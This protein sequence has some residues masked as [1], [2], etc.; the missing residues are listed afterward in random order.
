M[1]RVL[2]GVPPAASLEPLRFACNNWK[3]LHRLTMNRFI[4]GDLFKIPQ[5]SF[6][7]SSKTLINHHKSNS[8]FP[9][10]QL[11]SST[12]S[13]YQWW[14]R[15]TRGP[16]VLLHH[17]SSLW[18]RHGLAAHAVAAEA[19]HRHPTR[20]ACNPGRARRTRSIS[21]RLPTMPV[22]LPVRRARAAACSLGRDALN[23]GRWVNADRV[24]P[25]TA[26]LEHVPVKDVVVGES[27]LVEQVAKELP[28][29]A[30]R[31][32]GRKP[33][34]EDV[35]DCSIQ[36]GS[37]LPIVWLLFKPHCPAVV[38]VCGEFGGCALAQGINWSS[39][40]FLRNAWNVD[41]E[42]LGKEGP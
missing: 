3:L 12:G 22:L 35:V 20:R 24:L 36:F 16:G 42:R 6:E 5:I 38:E 41:I 39:H 7:I 2:L 31:G 15:S 8:S 28:E 13:T 17:G 19:S 33:S 30:E 37:T 11:L 27:L 4:Q 32:H 40:L 10:C 18:D 9:S 23:H 21:C 14:L 26:K 29:V 34:G 25:G 1:C